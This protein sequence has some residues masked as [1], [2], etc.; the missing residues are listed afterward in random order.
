[1]LFRVYQKNIQGYVHSLFLLGLALGLFTL[2][3]NA[4]AD[5]TLIEID[6]QQQIQAQEQEYFLQQSL[7]SKPTVRLSVSPLKLMA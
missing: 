7:N 5:P 2:S 3:K 6:A 4:Q 1:M